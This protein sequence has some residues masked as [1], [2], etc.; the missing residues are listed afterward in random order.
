M[1]KNPFITVGGSYGGA[2]SAWY[3]A[4]YPYTTVGAI[5]SS[6][7]IE[8]IVNFWEYDILVHETLLKVDEQ[9]LVNVQELNNYVERQLLSGS[10]TTDVKRSFN[11][12]K[13]TDKEFLYYW[14]DTLA[15][16]VQFGKTHFLCNLL[17]TYTTVEARFDA[18]KE[19][20]RRYTTPA[21]YGAYYLKEVDVDF[22]RDRGERQWAW[23][24]CSELGWFFTAPA[25]RTLAMRSANV[26]V[27]FFQDWCN[28]I[29]GDEIFPFAV[30]SNLQRG[31]KRIE[32]TNL[33]MTT[34]SEDPWRAASLMESQ[35]GIDVYYIECDG[36]AHMVDLHAPVKSDSWALWWTRMK[37][38][39]QVSKWIAHN[40][41]FI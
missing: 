2:L 33:V 37:M 30:I 23:Q 8:S 29:F 10:D 13:L 25:N 16:I 3:R 32:A 34:A 7:M 12:S 39:N 15:E 24:V 22:R 35:N 6:A 21:R 20:A 14:A 18:V 36:C 9:C 5:A 41:G 11:A 26:S 19:Y 4:K 40:V 31:G 1:Q 28:D 38:K 17:A 27:Q